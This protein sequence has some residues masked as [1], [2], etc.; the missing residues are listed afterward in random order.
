M[1]GTRP[2][3]SEEI[4]QVLKHLDTIRDKTMFILGIKTGFRIQELLSIKV[5]DVMKHG[6]IVDVV[7]VKRRFTK[8]KAISRDVA[9]S[10]SAKDAIKNLIESESL[11]NDDYLFQSRKG[12][13]Q[14]IKRCQ[15]WTILDKAFRKAKLQGNLGCH[16]MRKTFAKTVHA[17]MSFDLVK[18]KMALGHRSIMSTITYLPIN[19][20]DVNTIV[21]SI[22]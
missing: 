1:A 15:A 3:T 21:S 22:E 5:D 4:S 12:K 19:Q 18:T 2:L 10:Q 16:S 20:E 8:G 9:L 17:A 13:N 7:R 14:A 11:A 6:T